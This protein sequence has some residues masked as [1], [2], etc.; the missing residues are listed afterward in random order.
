MHTI[1]KVVDL[2]WVMSIVDGWLIITLENGTV[3]KRWWERD[4]EVDSDWIVKEAA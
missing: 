2:N 3:A 1:D 4:M